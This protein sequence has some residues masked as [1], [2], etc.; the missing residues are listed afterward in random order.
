MLSHYFKNSLFLFSLFLGFA[1]AFGVLYPGHYSMLGTGYYVS[2]WATTLVGLAILFGLRAVSIQRIGF[3]TTTWL[4]LALVVSIQPLINHIHYPDGLIFPIGFLL[5]ASILSVVVVNLPNVKRSV[6]VD[7]IA[8]CLLIVGLLS[9]VTQYVQLFYPNQFDFILKVSLPISRSEGNIAQPNQ[10]SFIAVLSTIAVFYLS[11]QFYFTIN[12]QE[13]KK[14]SKNKIIMMVAFFGFSLFFLTS[15]IALTLSR[16]GLVLFVIGLF[17]S[18]FYSWKSHQGRIVFFGLY[19]IIA[20]LGYKFGSGLG[21]VYLSIQDSTGI[22]RLMATGSELRGILWERAWSAFLSNPITGIGYN[23]Y[24]W[25]GWE[26]IENL[27]WFENANHAHNIILQ[28]GAELGIIGLMMIIGVVYVLC[29]Q[30]VLFFQ[31]RLTAQDL[32]LCIMLADFVAYSFSEFPL[33]YPFFAFPF[34][35]FVSLLDKGFSFKLDIK[36]ILLVLTVLLSS[37][38]T[39]YSAFYHYYLTHYE[40]VTVAKVE[41]QQKIDAYHNFPTIPGFIIVKEHMLHIIVDYEKTDNIDRFIKMGDR[42]IRANP[43]V[44]LLSIQVHLLMKYGRLSEA[45]EL[46]RKLCILEHQARVTAKHSDVNCSNVIK[47]IFQIDSNDSMGYAKRLNEWYQQRY[48]DE[49]K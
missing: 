4:G 29:H 15:A 36:K 31:K 40:I 46:N 30:L 38:A 2:L 45:D 34:V 10:A 28:I 35:I 3:S 33:W 6:I 25:Y 19:V 27:P 43:D 23:N 7:G 8:W 11:Y 12:N 18:L 17:G 9:A 26:N 13:I 39:F 14:Q 16:T 22:D 5:I 21:R 41:N 48:G 47:D 20:I 24:L 37:L 44:D 32:F 42:L 1:Y 49:N